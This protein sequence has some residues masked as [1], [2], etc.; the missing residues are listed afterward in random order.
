MS[1]FEAVILSLVIAWTPGIVLAAYLLMP[2]RP[3]ID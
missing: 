3:E 2:G 1:A